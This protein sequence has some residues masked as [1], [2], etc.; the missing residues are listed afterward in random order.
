MWKSGEKTRSAFFCQPV[1]P[2]A[3][4]DNKMCRFSP[5]DMWKTVWKTFLLFELDYRH[6]VLAL[7]VDSEP[8][9]LDIR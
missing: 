4:K 8:E 7:A 2:G 9:A 6:S 1:V 5:A 3:A